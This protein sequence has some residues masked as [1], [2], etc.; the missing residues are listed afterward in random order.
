MSHSEPVRLLIADERPIFRESL[1]ILIEFEP[2]FSVVGHAA[3]ISETIRLARD[4][5]PD[6]LLF[7]ISDAR[8]AAALQAL[9]TLRPPCPVLLLTGGIERDQLVELLRFGVRG[10][11]TTEAST[12]LLF[13]S[14]RCV[15]ANQY[16][17]GH[18][19]LSDLVQYVRQQTADASASRNTFGLTCRELQIVAAVAAGRTN[20]DIAQGFSLSEDTVK[21]HLSHIFD[22]VG[23]SNRLELALFAI[24]HQLVDEPGATSTSIGPQ[25]DRR[26]R[27]S[28]DES[29]A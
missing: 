19:S 28:L 9:E 23:A 13:K 10:V 22:K 8:V 3:N 21:H 12:E 20:K 2:G 25:R 15:I 26:G 29:P 11:V 6:A 1:R 17:V 24:H 14:I 18:E 27:A 7:A 4:L 16:W 5:R